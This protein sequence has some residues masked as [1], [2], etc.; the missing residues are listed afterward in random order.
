MRSIVSSPK[1]SMGREEK[2]ENIIFETTVLRRSIAGRCSVWPRSVRHVQRSNK[3][4]QK[5]KENKND[6]TGAPFF[7]CFSTDRP[8]LNFQGR[9]N[10]QIGRTE[11]AKT[12]KRKRNASYKGK[13]GVRK[14]KVPFKMV[15]KK[16]AGVCGAG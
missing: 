12:Q 2:L 14:K 6:F 9:L 10:M 7:Q 5:K 3:I 16:F 1:S 13:R 4:E 15:Q 11:N 8:D